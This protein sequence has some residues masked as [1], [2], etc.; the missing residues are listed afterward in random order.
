[1]KKTNFL[2]SLLLAALLGVGVSD[3]WGDSDPIYSWAG[4]TSD[5][6]ETGGTA[7][8]NF[9]VHTTVAGTFYAMTIAGNSNDL[10]TGGMM[11]ELS[12]ALQEGD[13]IRVTGFQDK[14]ASDKATALYMSFDQDATNKGNISDTENWVNLNTTDGCATGTEPELKLYT[15]TAA[16]AGSNKITLIRT[17]GKTGTNLFI[18]KIQIVRP[19]VNAK[20][21]FTGATISNKSITGETGTMSWSTQWTT[22]PSID[23]DMFRVGD[24]TDGV[25]NLVGD[26]AGAKD[27][28][29]IS[30]DMGVLQLTGK[31]AEFKVTDVNSTVLVDESFCVYSGT[32][33]ETGK[34]TFGFAIGDIVSQAAG[35]PGM[36]SNVK[37]TFT[38]TFDYAT[39]KMTCKIVNK[40]GTT[41]KTV[42]MPDG[43]GTVKSF[44]V[45]SGYNTEA[46]R[47][48][49]DNLLITTTPGD[50]TVADADY[51]VAFVDEEGTE[52][53]ERVTRSGTPGSSIEATTGDKESFWG[54]TKKYYY[55]S[56]DA[57]GKTIAANGS[58]LLTVTYR[59]AET[60]NYTVNSSLGTLIYSSSTTEGESV[61]V[62][63]PT[64]QLSGGKLYSASAI[65]DNGKK[66]SKT[67]TVS[68]NNQTETIT[69]SENKSNVVFYTEGEGVS[70]ATSTTVSNAGVRASKCAAGYN[71]TG[72]NITL[73]T[74]TE[75]GTYKITVATYGS[76]GSYSST[77]KAGDISIVRYY[78][79][80]TNGPAYS[81]EFP[82]TESTDI[83]W[84]TTDANHALDYIY[85]EKLSNEASVSTTVS[86]AGYATYV[87]SNYDLD[88]T[89]TDIKA[90]KVKVSSKETA[91]LTKVD[92]VPAGTPVL[93]Y[94]EGG[95]TNYVPV[96]TG[97]AAVEDNDLVA[98]SGAKVATIDGTYTNMILNKVDDNIGFYFANDNTVASDRA[99]LHIA[100]SLAPT[101]ASRMVMV[102]ADEVSGIRTIEQSQPASGHYYNLSGQRVAQPV[103]G[104]YIVNGKKVIKK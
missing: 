13:I 66:Y 75:V 81:G 92:N 56:D 14:N 94:K 26:A 45:R 86:D 67:F 37:N 82:I 33:F 100:T 54:D 22:V 93:L 16:L 90:Y 20:F 48:Y 74:L 61:T 95:A 38:L 25:V 83:I 1:M 35:D 63:Y 57:E 30:F 42:D 40:N 97:A 68:T 29:T 78:Y 9:S 47:C 70:D 77:I 91:V 101:A 102:F 58:T 103:K 10:S 28:V 104:L 99:Y 69:Y 76:K 24:M 59:E 11:I 49:F 71:G 36:T 34:N 55:K 5:A 72:E 32:G 52:I 53:K 87:N 44:A 85:I 19:V 3:A 31:Y 7:T 62:P 2:K 79:P 17:N 21:T 73:T 96:M 41:T 8:G 98:G 43:A 88:F 60:F 51:T 64:F 65:D 84:P 15:V 89:D 80:G 27:L 12:S 18:N 23:N 4:G 39:K 6:T 50:Y 46:R